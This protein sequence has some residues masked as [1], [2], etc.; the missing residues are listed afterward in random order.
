MVIAERRAGL[1][2]AVVLFLSPLRPCQRR[3]WISARFS[4]AQR[5]GKAGGLRPSRA[6][7]RS[8]R[9]ATGRPAVAPLLRGPGDGRPPWKA[10]SLLPHRSRWQVTSPDQYTGFPL[11][12]ANL[13]HRSDKVPLK[14]RLP[15]EVLQPRGTSPTASCF[16]GSGTALLRG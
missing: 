10:P 11:R 1:F 2:S 12:C 13:S 3:M 15:V 8:A 4:K 5:A 9:T 16:V 6:G 14:H 7:Q